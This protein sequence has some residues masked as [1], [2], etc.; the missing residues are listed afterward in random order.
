MMVALPSLLSPGTDGNIRGAKKGTLVT[1]TKFPGLPVKMFHVL[2]QGGEEC[3][4]SYEPLRIEVKAPK[5]LYMLKYFSDGKIVTQELCRKAY[6]P[7]N[8]SSCEEKIETGEVSQIRP[9]HIMANTS[10]FPPT[11][12]RVLAILHRWMSYGSLIW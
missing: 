4:Q 3:E 7:E 9:E 5:D 11:P 1:S 8:P 10:S 6:P 12:C 2:E